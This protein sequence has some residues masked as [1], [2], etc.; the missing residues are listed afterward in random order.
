MLAAKRAT[1]GQEARRP[2]RSHQVRYESQL[3]ERFRGMQACGL[4]RR[5]GPYAQ[6]RG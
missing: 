6:P 2:V 3:A 1:P 5:L 4:R